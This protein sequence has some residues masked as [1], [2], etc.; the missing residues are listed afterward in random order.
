MLFNESLNNLLDGVDTVPSQLEIE[1]KF[2]EK[3]PKVLEFVYGRPVIEQFLRFHIK[4]TMHGCIIDVKGEDF[5]LVSIH[6]K[7]KTAFSC[8]IDFESIPDTIPVRYITCLFDD[9]LNIES[10]KCSMNFGDYGNQNSLYIDNIKYFNGQHKRKIYLRN[11]KTYVS[12]IIDNLNPDVHKEDPEFEVF[13]RKI[14]LI[15][16]TKK[17]LYQE[18]FNYLPVIDMYDSVSMGT[19]INDLHYRYSRK[20]I[21]IEQSLALFEMDKI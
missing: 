14:M 9:D 1:A 12:K 21:L 2:R 19:F 3:I 5:N 17:E 10:F 15:N 13:L 4:K 8:D 16:C 20:D 11:I 6:T 7:E 18:A